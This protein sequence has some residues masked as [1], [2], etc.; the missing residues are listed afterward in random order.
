MDVM[1]FSNKQLGDRYIAKCFFWHYRTAVPAQDLSLVIFVCLFESRVSSDFH[2]N[3]LFPTASEVSARSG[4]RRILPN[5]APV[6]W[7]HWQVTSRIGW[8]NGVVLSWVP[9]VNHWLARR[10]G[11]WSISLF[12][13]DKQGFKIL[14]RWRARKGLE[15]CGR[16]LSSPPFFILAEGSDYGQWQWP[17]CPGRRRLLGLVLEVDLTAGGA[18]S[19][20]EPYPKLPPWPPRHSWGFTVPLPPQQE[21]EQPLSLE[22][23]WEAGAP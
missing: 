3:L 5:R 13:I 16:F 21:K 19:W 7:Q 23:G 18:T 22:E 8:C 9:L 12:T 1:W 14:R 11:G 6:V 2:F 4:Q 10:G 20:A 17:V 15:R